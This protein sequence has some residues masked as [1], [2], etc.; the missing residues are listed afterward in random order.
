M[1]ELKKLTCYHK[2]REK[3]F[4]ATP[5][6]FLRPGTH[7]KPS[8]YRRGKS[9][10]CLL[11]LFITL[12]LFWLPI[13]MKMALYWLMIV[14][15]GA[16]FRLMMMDT[17]RSELME[18]GVFEPFLAQCRKIRKSE[19]KTRTVRYLPRYEFGTFGGKMCTD[20]AD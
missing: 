1:H 6:L 12:A 3:V 18:N 7:K 9:R 2:W 11:N 17:L 15:K 5:A 10:S 8:C 4:S 19:A 14:P 20:S 13:V 16:L